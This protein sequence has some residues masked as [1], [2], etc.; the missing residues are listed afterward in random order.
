MWILE[1]FIL[2]QEDDAEVGDIPAES[3]D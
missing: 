1:E 3:I 2:D